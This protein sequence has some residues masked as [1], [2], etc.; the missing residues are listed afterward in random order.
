MIFCSVVSI[1]FTSG[2]LWPI[3]AVPWYFRWICDLN[4][5]TLPLNALRSIMLRGFGMDN[6]IVLKGFGQL[7]F[8]IVILNAFNIVVFNKLDK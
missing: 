8:Y 4:T 1:W 3:E 7:I 6:P 5:F 2:I